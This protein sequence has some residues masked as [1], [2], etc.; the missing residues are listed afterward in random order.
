MTKNLRI[1][2]V[3]DFFK[4]VFAYIDTYDWVLTFLLLLQKNLE[5]VVM[6]DHLFSFQ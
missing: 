5:K 1:Q 4:K 3:T 2:Y 6:N